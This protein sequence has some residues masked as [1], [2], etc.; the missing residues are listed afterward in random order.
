MLLRFN[1]YPHV[2]RRCREF[3]LHLAE[4]AR[5][6]FGCTCVVFFRHS[7]CRVRTIRHEAFGA[8]SEA[9][10]RFSL[11]LP[12][13]P[14]FRVVAAPHGD[15]RPS[16]S[17]PDYGVDRVLAQLN[18]TRFFARRPR[19][20]RQEVPRVLTGNLSNDL[21]IAR[22]PSRRAT[23]GIKALH[24]GRVRDC[25]NNIVLGSGLESSNGSRSYVTFGVLQDSLAQLM[26]S[27]CFADIGSHAEPAL[28]IDC[29]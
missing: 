21:Q 17:C 16:S 8:R 22:L 3:H 6:P 1:T 12:I 9:A 27:T 23:R 20:K 13:G 4:G 14:S 2:L 28:D 25:H 18:L 24:L 15:P 26:F 19:R 10:R 5:R 7:L 11:G 29:T